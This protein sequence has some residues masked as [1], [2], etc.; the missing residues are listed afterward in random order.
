MSIAA[1]IGLGNPGEEYAA[2][3]HNVGFCVV[4]ALA[5]QFKLRSWKRRGATLIARRSGARPVLLVKPQTFM[6]LSGE[7]VVET[8]RR[9][10]LTPAQCLVVV[11]DVDL[12]LGDL[13]LRER[14]G[15]GTHNGLRSVVESV[16]E[17][18]PRLRV[19]IG[20]VATWDD[21]ADYV[22]SEFD[23]DERTIVTQLIARSV[24]CV[25]TALFEGL[26]RAAS[27]YNGPLAAPAD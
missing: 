2:T 20:G 3:R 8:C 10:R 19:G 24:E 6:N 22:L 13:R 4:E 1:V 27:R 25:E 26:A 9:E 11:D 15:P 18:F 7:A 17:D 14:G 16:G 5:R 21:L 23:A 12:P